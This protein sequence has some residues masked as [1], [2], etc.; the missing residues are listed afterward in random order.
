MRTIPSVSGHV[1]STRSLSPPSLHS[2][3][4]TRVHRYYG[5]LRLPATLRFVLAFYTR[6]E[7]S[8][9]SPSSRDLHG[10]RTFF[11]QARSGLGSRVDVPYSPVR[12][13]HS[14]LRMFRYPRPA[15]MSAFSG[16]QPSRQ[17]LVGIQPRLLS[18]L[19]ISRVVTN[20]T[21]SL[22]TEPVASSCSGGTLTR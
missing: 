18:Q 15:P 4:V 20:M 13:T 10:Y 9:S 14:R 1:S 12:S 17:S 8:A 2:R 7:A 22:D 11:I 19:R 21:A 3:S 16:L 6:L 5:W